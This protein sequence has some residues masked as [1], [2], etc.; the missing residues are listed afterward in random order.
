MR[1]AKTKAFVPGGF[2]ALL[3]VATFVAML[4]LG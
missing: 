3:S 1:F 2:M 4:V